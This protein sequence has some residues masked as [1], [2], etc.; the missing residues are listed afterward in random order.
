MSDIMRENPLQTRH[1][2]TIIIVSVNLPQNGAELFVNFHRIQLQSM[3]G[4]PIRHNALNSA[5]SGCETFL[6]EGL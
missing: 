1:P 3:G 2:F 4:N 6:S 5:I